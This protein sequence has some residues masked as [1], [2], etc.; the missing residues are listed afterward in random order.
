MECRGGK[1]ITEC[2]FRSMANSGLQSVAEGY[3]EESRF[4]LFTEGLVKTSKGEEPLVGPSP[5]RSKAKTSVA[6]WEPNGSSSVVLS[7]R[8]PLKELN[9]KAKS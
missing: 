5:Q 4:Q 9:C 6:Y 2:D 3:S 1:P 8:N 7:P